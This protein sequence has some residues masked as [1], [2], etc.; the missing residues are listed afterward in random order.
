L[1]KTIRG[2]QGALVVELSVKVRLEKGQVALARKTTRHAQAKD[3]DDGVAVLFLWVY[4]VYD[5]GFEKD[6][7]VL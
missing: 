7:A 4:A 1:K 5:E 2:S 6:G 3:E